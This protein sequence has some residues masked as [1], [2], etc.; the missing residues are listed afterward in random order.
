VLKYSSN[1]EYSVLL[2]LPLKESFPAWLAAGRA[3]K[4]PHRF[5]KDQDSV[6]FAPLTDRKKKER[7]V[8]EKQRS[9]T[10][11]RYQRVDKK[12]AR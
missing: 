2:S 1:L 5:R 9:F 8:G 6:A 12:A 3:A 11:K 10:P 7:L 4:D